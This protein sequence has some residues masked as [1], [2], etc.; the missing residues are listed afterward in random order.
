VSYPFALLM[1]PPAPTYPEY[2]ALAEA[3][4]RTV[5]RFVDPA[6]PYVS[7]AAVG[8]RGDDWCTAVL[9]FPFDGLRRLNA[10]QDQLLKL[11]DEAGIDPPLPGWI[12]EARAEAAQRR[13]ELLERR[14]AAAQADADTWSAAL[15]QS[16]VDLE[17]R[18]GSRPRVRGGTSE[19]LRHAV[20]VRDVYS[21][22]R[23]TRTHPAGR[24]LCESEHRARPLAL[25]ATTDLPATCARCLQW[26]PQVRPTITRVI[27]G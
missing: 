24:A 23:T 4:R 26:T 12:V 11:A 17:V 2:A 22:V 5:P 21:G 3:A 1:D 14:R 18:E 16:A 20:P 15:A 8:R 6:Q 25:G 7:A 13:T 27:P 10:V 19:Y 9:G